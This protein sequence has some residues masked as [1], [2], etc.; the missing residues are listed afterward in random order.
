MNNGASIQI[1]VC[2]MPKTHAH[3]TIATDLPFKKIELLTLCKQ[4]LILDCNINAFNSMCVLFFK[5]DRE[6][7]DSLFDRIS[8]S[9]VSLFMSIPLSRKDAFFQVNIEINY[10]NYFYSK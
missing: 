6:S 7:Q 8:E 9:Y 10:A 4:V 3:P 2:M 5:P 1:Q